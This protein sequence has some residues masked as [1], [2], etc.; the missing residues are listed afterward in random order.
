ML[1]D[2]VVKFWLDHSLDREHGGYLHMLDREGRPYSTDKYAWPHGREVWFFATLCDEVEQRSEWFEAAQHGWEFITRHFLAP[3]DRVH[4]SVNREGKPL[5]I[6]RRI[7]SEC[8]M[9]IAAARWA[10]ISGDENAARIARSLFHAT[11]KRAT[12]PESGSQKAVPGARPMITMAIPM[13]MMNVTREIMKLDGETP[14]LLSYSDS[15]IQTFLTMHVHPE[16]RLAFENVAPD[17][18]LMLDQPEGRM[19]IPGH[20]IE[21]AWFVMEEGI[22]RNDQTLIDRACELLE[23]ELEFGWDTEYGGLNYFMDS[24]GLP[25]LPLESDM[26][27]WWCHNEAL[28]ALLYALT[29]SKNK[30]FERWYQKVHDYTFSTFPDPDHGEWIGYFHRDGRIVSPVKGSMWKCCFHLPRH[31][32]I[33]RRLLS[34]LENIEDE[35][36]RSASDTI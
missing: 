5:S 11:V 22:A 18:S 30:I 10:R 29:L 19:L 17:G 34:V 21:G 6:P 9:I 2:N 36:G 13:I 25:T 32:L 12:T 24:E 26:K 31:L 15:C 14:E 27:L 33:G 16:R 23:W 20:A 28:I 3:G 8:F 1:F 7:F 4:F 35:N